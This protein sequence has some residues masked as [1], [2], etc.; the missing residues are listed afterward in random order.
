M[1]RTKINGRKEMKEEKEE[2]K[3]RIKERQRE[4]GNAR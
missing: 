1:R 3:W 2:K 4:K